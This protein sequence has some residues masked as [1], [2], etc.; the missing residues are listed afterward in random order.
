MD[1][2]NARVGRN[3]DA[4]GKVLGKHGVGNENLNGTR[5]LCLCTVHQ[6]NITNTMFQQKNRRKTSWQHP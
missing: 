5:L 6:L 3:S 1:D 2:F 4:W